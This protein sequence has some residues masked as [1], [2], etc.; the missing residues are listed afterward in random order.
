MDDVWISNMPGVVV[1]VVD[2]VVV[3]HAMIV[4]PGRRRVSS[5]RSFAKLMKNKWGPSA[6]PD[7]GEPKIDDDK[8]YLVAFSFYSSSSSVSLRVEK[9]NRLIGFH[10]ALMRSDSLFFIGFRFHFLGQA[11]GWWK[12]IRD[13]VWTVFH[14]TLPR[15]S[16]NLFL[17][18]TRLV[19]ERETNQVG[20]SDKKMKKKWTRN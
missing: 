1:D 8:D 3:E 4:R 13:S 7:E 2:V 20:P 18:S 9:N 5:P 15:F 16:L 11:T 6:R 14:S 10:L 12:W 19:K 17:R